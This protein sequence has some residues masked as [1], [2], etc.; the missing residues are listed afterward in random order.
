MK[1]IKKFWNEQSTAL[2]AF[3]IAGLGLMLYEK[4]ARSLEIYL[5]WESSDIGFAFFAGSI[6]VV[7]IVELLIKL[8]IFK[9]YY[10][11]GWGTAL[12]ILF[13]ALFVGVNT[14]FLTSE[15]LSVAKEQIKNNK[16]IDDLVGGIK[17]FGWFVTGSSS[18]TT[19]SAGTSGFAT[20]Q[21]LVKGNE[22]YRYVTVSLSK[23]ADKP[24]EFELI[25][26]SR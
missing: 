4:I 12:R 1:R 26:I 17:G 13:I 14:I 22:V 3:A 2:K 7:L 21:V 23:Q 20:Y 24:W 19:N 10:R 9:A 25:G 5:F 18:T 16:Q 11:P 6:G 8:G 15:S